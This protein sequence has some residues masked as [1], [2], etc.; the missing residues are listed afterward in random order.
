MRFDA[1]VCGK[2]ATDL[3]SRCREAVDED[4]IVQF[5]FTLNNLTSD[6]FTLNKDDHAGGQRVSLKVRLIKVNWIKIGQDIIFKK[7]GFVVK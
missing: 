3:I 2:E 5:R 1:P 7:Q 6:T 4:Q